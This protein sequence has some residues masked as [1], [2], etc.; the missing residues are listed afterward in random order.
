MAPRTPSEG[1]CKLVSGWT[2]EV[3]PGWPFSQQGGQRSPRQCGQSEP[4]LGSQDREPDK[5]G[6]AGLVWLAEA[7]GDSTNRRRGRKP[8]GS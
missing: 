2:M 1:L 5:E 6:R 4:V 3:Q 7:G 8:R